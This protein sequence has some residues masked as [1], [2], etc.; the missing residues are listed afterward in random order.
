MRHLLGRL[1]NAG[2]QVRDALAQA[3]LATQIFVLG[4]TAEIELGPGG[5]QTR[6]PAEFRAAMNQTGER[7]QVVLVEFDLGLDVG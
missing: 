5:Q 3:L 7:R 2:E 1:R 6:L 4:K